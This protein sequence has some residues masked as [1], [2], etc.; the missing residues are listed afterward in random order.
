MQLQED[1]SLSENTTNNHFKIIGPKFF[2]IGVQKGGT[3]SLYDLLIQHENICASCS[4][5]GEGSDIH[6]NMKE[7]HYFDIPS[8][9]K[10]GSSFY[11]RHFRSKCNILD[12][13]SNYLDGTPDYYRHD[14]VPSRMNETFLSLK[15]K[16]IVLILR[17]PISR[18]FSLYI[19]VL[20][21][22][23]NYIE[24]QINKYHKK[25]HNFSSVIN[26]AK[27]ICGATHNHQNISQ[28]E[29]CHT[30]DCVSRIQSIKS[31]S[32]VI[33]HL[34]TFKEYVDSGKISYSHS[35]YIHQIRNYLNFFDRKQMLILSFDYL[36]HNTSLALQAIFKHFDVPDT[37]SSM[38]LPHDNVA[39]VDAVLD[40]ESQN[41]LKG[42]YTQYN[43]L[44]Y[45][46]FE[47]E[48]GPDYEPK[49]EKFQYSNCTA[50]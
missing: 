21:H 35:Q 27:I 32:K 26:D 6:L 15:D 18:E 45:E 28:S 23:T 47:K 48:K 39:R 14:E 11:L 12:G 17:E 30:L 25:H 31:P 9:Y 43:D 1:R 19:H 36:I 50:T 16:R 8:H 33:R 3:T 10:M 2:L 42:Y 44:L 37:M 34:P 22:C 46:F 29:H 13:V 4:A 40:C 5:V 20:R 38:A 49:F 41:K 24:N 7:I